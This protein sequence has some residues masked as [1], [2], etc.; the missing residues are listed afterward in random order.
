[1]AELLKSKRCSG[2]LAAANTETAA[3]ME[4]CKVADKFVE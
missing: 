3:T 2:I 4:K 1:M